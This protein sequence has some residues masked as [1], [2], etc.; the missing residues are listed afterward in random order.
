[1]SASPQDCLEESHPRA[2]LP[3]EPACQPLR[4]RQASL[5]STCIDRLEYFKSKGERKASRVLVSTLNMECGVRTETW[6]SG[7][8]LVRA[9]QP[10]AALT[11]D[12]HKCPPPWPSPLGFTSP[13]APA[14][15]SQQNSSV[16]HFPARAPSDQS[17]GLTVHVTRKLF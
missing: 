10:A 15:L 5:H 2:G 13:A 4:L 9:A 8:T 12:P 1:M 6:G 3:G 7:R 11:K 17:Q 14:T 16:P